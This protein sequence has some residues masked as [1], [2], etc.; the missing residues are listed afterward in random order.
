MDFPH[1]V[2]VLKNVGTTAGPF[3]GEA[4]RWVVARRGVPCNVQRE[5]GREVRPD[6]GEIALADYVILADPNPPWQGNSR[7]R[8]DGR[9]L[10]VMDVDPD[11]AG[12][13]HHSETLARKETTVP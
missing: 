2:D 11:P 8:W 10:I 7:L 5:R 3:G 12:R 6:V 1:R 9:T 13:G 4:E